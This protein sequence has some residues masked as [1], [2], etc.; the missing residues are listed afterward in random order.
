MNVT[1]LIITAAVA[2]SAIAAGE[3][4][5]MASAHAEPWGA[6]CSANEPIA[7]PGAIC[8]AI[9]PGTGSIPGSYCF[10]NPYKIPSC[11]SMFGN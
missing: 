5:S 9:V 10:M 6:Y 3:A 4:V 2:T 11:R 1:K 7:P 8:T